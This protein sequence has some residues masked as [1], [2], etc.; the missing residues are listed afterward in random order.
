[1]YIT[2]IYIYIISDILHICKYNHPQQLIAAEETTNL[3]FTHRKPTSLTNFYVLS[4][5]LKFLFHYSINTSTDESE[6]YTS[7]LECRL[8]PLF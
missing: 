6:I 5:Y 4:I 2:I 3:I 7:H 8:N 1:M